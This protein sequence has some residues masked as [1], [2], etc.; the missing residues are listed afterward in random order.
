MFATAAIAANVVAI[1]AT[2]IMGAAV[3]RNAA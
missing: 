3:G 1:M 2:C